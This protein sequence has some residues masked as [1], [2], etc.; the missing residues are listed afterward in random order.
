VTVLREV[1]AEEIVAQ[2]ALEQFSP[3]GTGPVQL[4]GR[5]GDVPEVHNRQGR[6]TLAEQG[7]AEGQVIILEPDNGVLSATLVRRDGREVR[8]HLLVMAPM[9]GIEH[10]TLQIEVTQGPQGAI[11]K[12]R[13]KPCH[14]GLAQP[15]A[16]QRVLGVVRR[17]LHVILGVDS[18]AIGAATPPGDPGAVAG[19]HDRVESRGE[20]A[21]RLTPAQGVGALEQAAELGG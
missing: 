1:E 17:H 16:P 7:R 6:E 19:L 10:R 9:E 21:R 2:Q 11:G 12:A 18:L 20:A 4:P 3:P 15:H 13:V 14:L 8:I 5:P